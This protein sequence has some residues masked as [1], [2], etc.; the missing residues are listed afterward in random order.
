MSVEEIFLVRG[1]GVT[2]IFGGIFSAS[3]EVQEVNSSVSLVVEILGVI[4]HETEVHVGR[5]VLA[6]EVVIPSS[7][8]GHHKEAKE[9]IG[10]NHLDFLKQSRRVFWR[11]R[12]SCHSCGILVALG[13]IL[14]SPIKALTSQ[15]IHAEGAGSSCET[16]GSYNT[17]FGIPF[18]IV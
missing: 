4:K 3:S 18:R 16:T 10:E 17:G 6:V 14:L 13:K 1:V 5:E 15:L 7:S 8:F 11:V 12:L 9:L 2:C